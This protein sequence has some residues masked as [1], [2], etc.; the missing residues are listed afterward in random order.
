MNPRRRRD[1]QSWCAS[2]SYKSPRK[3]FP[4]IRQPRPTEAQALALIHIK[5]GIANPIDYEHTK[6]LVMHCAAY[7]CAYVR[8]KGTRG[9]TNCPGWCQLKWKYEEDAEKIRKAWPTKERTKPRPLTPQET[10]AFQ[11]LTNSKVTSENL[12]VAEA[13]IRQCK[14]D[15]CAHVIGSAAETESGIC[16]CP[17]WCE[18]RDK[19]LAKK[20]S[21]K[22]RATTAA[23]IKRRADEA[24]TTTVREAHK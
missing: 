14:A 13:L 20:L 7:G 5:E 15:G 8:D 4:H 24:S 12:L 18:I 6:H 3:V 9:H 23:P 10:Q 17:G 22:A 21:D 19:A 2:D 11:E 16:L 1:T